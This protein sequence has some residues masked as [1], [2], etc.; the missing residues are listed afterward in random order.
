MTAFPSLGGSGMVA[1][2]LAS[3]LARRG[4]QVHFLSYSR[5]YAF[6]ED[7]KYMHIHQVPKD[8]YAL[9]QDIGNLYTI[10]LANSIAKIMKDY[11]INIFNSHYGIPH[12]TSAFLAKQITPFES[13]T[14]LHGSDTHLLGKADAFNALMR[15]SLESDYTV[16]AVSNFLAN[17][18]FQVFH[19]SKRP[20]VIYDWIDTKEFAP[21]PEEREKVIIHASNFRKI[22]RIPYLIDLFAKVASD[23]PEW[24]LRLIGDGPERQ[25]CYRKALL[26][27]LGDRIDFIDPIREIP[28]AFQNAAI[29]VATSE[30]ESFG[31]TLGEAMSTETPVITSD[32]GGTSE[33]CVDGKTGYLFQPNDM[34]EAVGKLRKLMED[35]DLRR[36]FGK[37]GRQRIIEKFSV[38]HIVNQY[39]DL[40]KKME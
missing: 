33:V 23:F 5:P 30:M 29:L 34:D 2:R 7:Q 10:K 27:N 6:T 1:T 9:F 14:T 22:K 25:M 15:V 3:E 18:A 21:G 32:V 37:A 20:T 31:L 24:K 36:K 38:D 26:L 12:S 16:T 28:Q 19:L 35:E 11:D 40:Y 4:H 17:L 8:T 13:V 39:L